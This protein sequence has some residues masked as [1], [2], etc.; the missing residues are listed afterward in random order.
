MNLPMGE[1]GSL[2]F[3]SN[4]LGQFHENTEQRAEQSINGIKM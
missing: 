4:E 3:K 2:A 1:F